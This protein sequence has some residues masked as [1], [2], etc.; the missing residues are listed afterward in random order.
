LVQRHL[1]F[2]YAAVNV[3][4]GLVEACDQI[5]THLLKSLSFGQGSEWAQWKTLAAGCGI[6]CWFCEPDS[7]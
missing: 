4:A 5:P 6:D 1:V 2:S 7:P 3:L